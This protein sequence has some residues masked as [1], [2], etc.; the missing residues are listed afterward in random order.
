MSQES[1][2]AFKTSRPPRGPRHAFCAWWGWEA[3][4]TNTALNEAEQPPYILCG[5]RRSLVRFC[6]ARAARAPVVEALLRRA[7]RQGRQLYDSSR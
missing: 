6:D 2:P 7:G 3:G 4:K 5:P 1:R